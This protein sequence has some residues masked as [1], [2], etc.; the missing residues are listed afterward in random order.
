MDGAFVDAEREF[1]AAAAAQVFHGAVDL[2]AQVEHAL[3][4]GG[5]QLAGVGELAGAR[6]AGKQR[7]AHRFFEL[8]DGD[9]DRGLGA[10]ELLC[11]AGEA[12]LARHGEEDVQFGEVHDS[13]SEPQ[14]RLTYK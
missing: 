6:A 14:V 11:G 2:V 3:G 10:K 5:Q 13:E 7:L 12:V 8:A 9:A 1:A 4:I